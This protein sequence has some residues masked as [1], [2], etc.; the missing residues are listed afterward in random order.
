M[1]KS[2]LKQLTERQYDLYKVI[3]VYISQDLAGRQQEIYLD[4]FTAEIDGIQV[5]NFF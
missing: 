2:F 5:P 1:H 3:V 4:Q